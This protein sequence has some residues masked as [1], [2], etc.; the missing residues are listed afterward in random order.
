MGSWVY[1]C[2]NKDPHEPHIFQVLESHMSSGV[3]EFV[4]EDVECKGVKD[5]PKR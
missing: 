4:W 1:Q 2:K 3:D 5:D